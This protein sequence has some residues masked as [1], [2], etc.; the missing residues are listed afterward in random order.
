ML[1]YLIIGQGIAGTLLSYELS[2]ITNHLLVLDNG[3]LNSSSHVAAGLCNPITGRFLKK[4]WLADK[5]FTQLK[6][7]YKAL[8]NQLNIKFLHPIPVYRKYNNIEEQNRIVALSAEPEWKNYIHITPDNQHY[9]QYMENDLGG[10]E[11]CESFQV[12]GSTLLNAWKNY[13]IQ[14]NQYQEEHFEE[15]ELIFESEYISY[16]NIKA[17]KVIFC[18]GFEEQNSVFFGKLPFSPVKGEWIKIKTE[19]P[20]LK[21]VINKDCFILPHPNQ[22]WTV[23]ATYH[24]DFIDD[25]ITEK[26]TQELKEKLENVLKIPYQ[27]IEQRAGIRPASHTRRPFLGQ[28]KNYHN[29]FIFNGLGTKGYSLA[30]YFALQMADFLTNNYKEDTL[31]KEVNINYLKY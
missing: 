24:W 16:K 4:T 27:I 1:E 6:S 23:G 19:N 12:E 28:H 14:N 2:K 18:R 22:Q 11:T 26:A 30:P 5:L 20:D 17:K 8:E 15:K 21:G 7:T 10:W 29:L 31:N 25:K 3:N 9:A 13:L